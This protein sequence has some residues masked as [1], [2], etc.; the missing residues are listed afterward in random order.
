MAYKPQQV[1]V[2]RM[3]AFESKTAGFLQDLQ[4]AEDKRIATVKEDARL[5]R[6]ETRLDLQ[7]K[8]AVSRDKLAMEQQLWNREH[9]TA[10]DKATAAQVALEN[11]RAADRLAREQG[12]VDAA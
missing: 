9:T 2:S 10:Q 6:Q 4:T 1:S 3:P 8:R 5:D 12:R 11:Q 7:G